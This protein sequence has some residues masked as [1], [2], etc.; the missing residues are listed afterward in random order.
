VDLPNSD[1]TFRLM[2]W[3][4]PHLTTACATRKAT[5]TRSTL[6]L[7]KPAKALAGSSVLLSTAMEPASNAD[8]SKGYALTMTAKMAPAKRANRCQ[9]SRVSPS[10]MGVSQMPMPSAK[11]A[12]A[13]KAG[14]QR[15]GVA[16]MAVLR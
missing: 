5:T 12:R 9:A 13:F 7:A 6:G 8:V 11:G 4:S 10:G 16:F 3:P 2:R 15:D 1:T 14:I